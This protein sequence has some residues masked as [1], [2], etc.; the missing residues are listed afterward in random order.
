MRLKIASPNNKTIELSFD[1]FGATEA[2]SV[3]LEMSLKDRLFKNCINPIDQALDNTGNVL[4]Q[5]DVISK[6]SNPKANVILKD[7]TGKILANK[8]IYFGEN[9]AGNMSSSSSKVLI[10]F[11][12]LVVAGFALY[13]INLKKN[14]KNETIAQ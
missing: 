4:I 10:A 11:S 1:R 12:I 9:E 7:A 5:A 3:R 14:K 13:F 8:E 2:G 6:C